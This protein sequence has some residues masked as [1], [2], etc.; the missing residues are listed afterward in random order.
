MKFTGAALKTKL[1]ATAIHMSMSIAVFAFLAY[2]IYYNWYPQPYFEIDGGWQGIRLIAA[3]DLV[4]G[5][6]ITFL[7]FDLSKRMRAIIFDLV[8][9]LVIQFG[10]LAYGVYVTYTQRPIAV[11]LIDEFV[12]PAIM[13]HYGGK[14][15]ST[16]QL[17]RYSDEKPPIIYADLPL[18]E[19]QLAE[20]NRIK[21]EEKVLENA[22]MQLYRPQSGLREALDRLQ[23]VFYDRLDFFGARAALEEWLET[24][25]KSADEV[26]IARFEGRFGNAWLV[27]DRRGEYLSYFLNPEST[28]VE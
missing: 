11:V 1:K 2:Q 27:F 25:G 4:L 21:I 3:V 22:Q 20:I 14:L 6:V 5:P 13:E 24:H 28:V 18:D 16:E 7:I 23:P 19:A 26:L 12:V 15:E 17:S 8:V 9:I 10:A